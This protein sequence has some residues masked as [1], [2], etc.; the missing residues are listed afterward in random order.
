MAV[1]ALLSAALWGYAIAGD[2]LVRPDSLEPQIRRQCLIGPLLVAGVFTRIALAAQ[3]DIR[4]ARWAW[5]LLVPAAI[6]RPKRR[7]D[8]LKP[9][10]RPSAPCCSRS[11]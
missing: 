2:R 11:E 9:S 7:H 4:A 6:E 10:S 1:A 3:Y 5:L 8:G